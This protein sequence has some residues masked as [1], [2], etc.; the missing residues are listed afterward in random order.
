MISPDSVV[1]WQIGAFAVSATLVYT[2]ALMWLLALG[3]WLVTRRLSGE[4]A[5][6]RWQNLLEVL[7]AGIR[8]QIREVSRQPPDPYLPFVGTLFVFIAAANLLAVV[9]GYAPPTASLSTTAALA[10]A[11][12]VAVPVFGIAREGLRG[13]LGH[14]LRPSVFMLPFNLIAEVSRTIALAVRLY[15]NIM[16]GTVIAALLLSLAPFFVPVAMQLFGLLIGIVQ[17]YI[18]AVLAMVYIASATA[19][20]RD[21][22]DAGPAGPARSGAARASPEQRNSNGGQDG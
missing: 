22:G 12:F 5:L 19:A 6:S 15:G 20:H 7:V 1:F 17:A 14:Y 16:S 9:P 10:I 21:G 2:W 8:E 13:Y 18:F 3:S 4:L 11:V